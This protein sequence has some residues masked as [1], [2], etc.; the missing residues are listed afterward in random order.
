M[1]AQHLPKSNLSPAQFQQVQH[2]FE[3]AFELPPNKRDAWLDQ[4]TTL[5]HP[6]VDKARQLI[7]LSS[8]LKNDQHSLQPMPAIDVLELTLIEANLGNYQLLKILGEGGMGR[9]YLACRN[10]NA[11]DK[12]VVIKLMKGFHKQ[13]T[14]LQRFHFERQ[15]LAQLEH[16]YIARLLDGGECRDGTPFYVMEYVDGCSV[17]EYCRRQSLTMT[18]CLELFQKICSAVH[19]AHQNLVIHR[20]LKPNNILVNQAGE[21]KLLDFGIAK[22]VTT[23]DVG[24]APLTHTA[25]GPMTPSYSSPEQLLGKKLSITSDIYSLGTV[26]YE[27]LTQCAPHSEFNTDPL[28]FKAAICEHEPKIPSK[29]IHNSGQKLRWSNDLDNVVMK[30]LHKDPAKRYQSA[31]QLSD[32]LK[33]YNNGRSV[34][35]S[36]HTWFYH[37]TKLIRRHR[38][39]SSIIVLALILI[40][41][42]Q[43]RVLQQRDQALLNSQHAEQNRT[44]LIGMFDV[45]D[46]EISAQRETSAEMV[47]DHGARQLDSGMI[48]QPYIRADLMM[49][50]ASLYQK[51]GLYQDAYE[52]TDKAIRIRRELYASQDPIMADSLD[53]LANVYINQGQSDKALSTVQE[54]LSIIE[55]HRPQQADRYIRFMNTLSKVYLSSSQLEASKQV[56]LLSSATARAQLKHDTRLFSESLKMLGI[57]YLFLDEYQLAQK[58]LMESLSICVKHYGNSHLNCVSSSYSLGIALSK[59]GLFEQ[60]ELHYQSTLTIMQ[61]TRGTED[62]STVLVMNEIGVLMINTHRFEEAE[63]ILKNALALIERTLGTEHISIIALLDNLEQVYTETN[64]TDEALQTTER[65]RELRKKHIK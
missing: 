21:P 33:C 24:N 52:L 60:A 42:Q 34:S 55:P 47:L 14:T 45:L 64:R 3:K 51:H 35:A 30:A 65:V 40:S 4:Q 25:F 31:L 57:T 16:P 9:V 26:L 20:D 49:T 36:R 41:W 13:D 22:Q 39:A 23:N 17:T 44:F 12:Q 43:M 50:L 18:Q 63:V 15:T 19:Y 7:H 54:A 56:S 38:L 29:A 53:F 32:D 28:R 61:N 48:D 37:G 1:T 2:L 11:F 6:V 5:G 46:P 10:D 58:N 27:I 59:Q 8:Q 62:P